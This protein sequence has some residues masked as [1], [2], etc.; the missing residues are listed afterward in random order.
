MRE[1][2]LEMHGIVKEFS[3]VRVLD[4]VNFELRT[5]EVHALLGANGAGKSTLMKI[6]NGIYSLTAGDRH[7]GHRL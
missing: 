4:E 1:N 2:I 5:G 6:L 7:A 3:R